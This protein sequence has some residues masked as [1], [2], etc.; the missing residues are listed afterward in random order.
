MIYLKR[1]QTTNDPQMRRFLIGRATDDGYFTY[2]RAERHGTLFPN[3]A[4]VMAMAKFEDKQFEEALKILEDAIEA[5]PKRIEPYG[6][7]ATI[8]RKRRELRY[9]AS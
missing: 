4:V 6:A 2:S 3:I 7:L 5:Q 1:L 9:F 8:H